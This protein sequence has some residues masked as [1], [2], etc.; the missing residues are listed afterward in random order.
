[1]PE[2][3]VPAW[4]YQLEYY[5]NVGK[6]DTPEWVKATELL[7]W[8]MAGDA[9][10]YEAAWIDH[11]N[12]PVFTYARACVINFE[13]DTVIGNAFDAW[14]M[15]H[16]NE[17]DLPCEIARVFTW[18][19]TE[20]AKTADKASFLFT[21]NAPHNN[22]QGQPVTGSGTFNMIDETWTEGSWNPATKTFSE[23]QAPAP[24]A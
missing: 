24:E 14:M 20:S 1:M 7:S 18:L 4:G 8:E 6:T 17:T 22:N 3:N 2:S 9:K 13:K 5:V 10:T 16:R 21:P 12:P 11:K 15:E 23:G 19:G